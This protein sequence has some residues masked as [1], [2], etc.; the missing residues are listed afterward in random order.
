VSPAGSQSTASAPDRSS[1]HAGGLVA[2]QPG[3]EAAHNDGRLAPPTHAARANCVRPDRATEG[4]SAIERPETLSP[5]EVRKLPSSSPPA[6]PWPVAHRPESLCDRSRRQ[7]AARAS[8]C[9]S[10]CALEAKEYVPA[11]RFIPPSRRVPFPSVWG[12][13]GGGAPFL[14]PIQ[15]SGSYPQRNPQRSVP[16]RE[17]ARRVTRASATITCR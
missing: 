14:N 5:S 7:T 1:P 12:Q 17:P 4:L 9:N 16:R 6:A 2:G 13:E 10:T 15:A 3:S 8:G 11:F